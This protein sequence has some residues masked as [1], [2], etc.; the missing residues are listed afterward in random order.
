MPG[1]KAS[2]Q[3]SLV[4]SMLRDPLN[5]FPSY[6]RMR[7][8]ASVFYASE[9][10]SWFV[11]RY[12]DV[13]RVIDD[14]LLFS[15]EQAIRRH[16]GA[17][18]SSP[19][20][21][22][23]DPPRHGQLRALV[24]QAFN[25]R[26]IAALAPRIEQI[27][28]VQL[29]A[30][31]GQ[32]YMDAVRDLANPLPIIVIA[33]L[34]GVPAV[35]R[36]Q[37][38]RWSDLIVGTARREKKQAVIDMNAY[39]LT[40]LAHRRQQPAN[41][42]ISALLAAQIDGVHLTDA[43]LLSFCRL[44]LVAGHETSTN[45]IGNALLTLDEYPLAL[46]ELRAEPALIPAAVEGV[47]RY[48]TPIQRLRRVATADTVLGDCVIKAGEIVSPI[49]GS[50]NRDEAHFAQPELF[51]IPRSPERHLG[52]GHGIHFCL[53]AALARLETRLALEILL[54]RFARLERARDVPLQAVASSFV[55]GVQS[56]PMTFH[57]L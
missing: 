29:D 34:L 12:D 7:V 38:K 46:E 47:L 37:F 19:T 48:R 31:A 8:E 24:G 28:H 15:S 54:T 14:P 33:E 32:G 35:D 26:T 9:F 49:L 22:W 11:T 40:I 52:F 27:V 57:A 16:P 21:L 2:D 3:S 20:L 36:A 51:S 44:L 43:E 56:L 53:G 1:N 42:V 30:V 55:Y 10:R 45:L 39:F 4:A 6:S 50:A 41:D 25:P 5:P 23:T 17:K 13:Q 18:R